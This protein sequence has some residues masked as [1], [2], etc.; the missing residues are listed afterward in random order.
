MKYFGRALN[1]KNNTNDQ[2]KH[3]KSVY[4]PGSENKRIDPY[5][6]IELKCS[7]CNETFAMKS[8]SDVNRQHYAYFTQT[9]GEHAASCVSSPTLVNEVRRD[10]LNGNGDGKI[11]KHDNDG[12]VGNGDGKISH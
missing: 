3:Y 7:H 4:C 11:N 5:Y 8:T 6:K 9:K 12:D 2:F 10:D 1:K